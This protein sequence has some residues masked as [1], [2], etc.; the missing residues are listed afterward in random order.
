MKNRV[1]ST[2]RLPNELPPY[3]QIHNRRQL[4]YATSKA[5]EAMGQKKLGKAKKEK[6]QAIR[7]QVEA[8]LAACGERNCG[9]TLVRCT[10]GFA[11]M[12]V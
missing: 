3:P 7:V 2:P 9:S 4:T 8:A 6:L 5:D 10:R 1:M 12:Y 11:C